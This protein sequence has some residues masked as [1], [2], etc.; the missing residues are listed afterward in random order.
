MLSPL[1][2]ISSTVSPLIRREVSSKR[3]FQTLLVRPAMTS[4]I[5]AAISSRDR[6]SPA[7]S[8]P[9]VLVIKFVTAE[10]CCSIG[11]FQGRIR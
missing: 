7:E 3:R 4:S 6:F 1:A 8:R 5:I 11:A 2:A 9:N 10:M